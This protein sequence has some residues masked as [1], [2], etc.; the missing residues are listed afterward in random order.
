M[1][2]ISNL[3]SMD[4]S[5]V[6]YI[7]SAQDV[8]GEAIQKATT[9]IK[10]FEA[11][12]KTHTDRMKEHWNVFHSNWL[13][14]TAGIAAAT[15][16]MMKAW[17]LAEKAAQFEEQQ[18]GL[19]ALASQYGTT[20][21]AVTRM[22]KEAVQGQLSL[23]ESSKLAARALT[24]G[25][26]PQQM[27]A[28][29]EVSER[30]TDVV[31]GDIPAAFEAME[32][33]AATG[34]ARG[35]VQ[36]GIVVDLN[37]VLKKYADAHGIAKESISAHTAMQI[38]ANAIMEEAKRVTDRFGEG[39][40]TTADKMNRMRATVED[41]QL[42]LGQ[43]L[44]RA[45]LAAVGV[46]DWLKAGV[47][48][49][50]SSVPKVLEWMNRLSAWIYEKTGQE[51]RAAGA[52]REANRL[53]A[54]Y[55]AMQISAENAAGAAGEA[56]SAAFAST[57][58]LAKAMAK[59]SIIPDTTEA[60]DK[61]KALNDRI[62]EQTAKAELDERRHAEWQ[63]AEW[64]KQGAD[65]ILV[66]NWL[67]AEI[68]KIEAK[69]ADES[70]KQAVEAV[71]KEMEART[72]A[73]VFA[74][75]MREEEI[76]RIGKEDK[77]REKAVNSWRQK[78]YEIYEE[79]N[80]K[81]LVQEKKAILA[82]EKYR[83]E[84]TKS[85]YEDAYAQMMTM[86]NQVGGETGKGLGMMGAGLKGMTDIEMRQDKYSQEI[87]AA[88]EHY[89]EMEE[90]YADHEN[91]MNIM[92]QERAQRDAAIERASAMQRVN[93]MSSMAGMMA[94]TMYALYQATGQQNQ[95][96]L[97]AYKVF[98]TAQAVMDTYRAANS[99]LA[100][101]PYPY[102]FIVAAAVVAAGLANVAQIMS[103]GGGGGTAATGATPAGGGGYAYT[104]PTEPS[105]QKAEPTKA[106]PIINITILGNVV[107]QG[108]FVRSII[109]DIQRAYQDGV[110]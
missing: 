23:V 6:N 76:K 11:D 63:A 44:V 91:F 4:I 84:Y 34:R 56:F 49:V 7:I 50:A 10:K 102:N 12:T 88:I 38:R 64:R 15:V 21:D 58:E 54:A 36:Y 67:A 79:W 61:I 40:D 89:Y 81:M 72:E 85:Q 70:I 19:Q 39:T 100:T 5:A 13:K 80:A 46:F 17:D 108:Q 92:T 98:A 69:A 51:D 3:A 53:K 66:A 68:K 71:E 109:P 55:D 59:T 37:Q 20:A 101:V 26:N 62:R 28:F 31:G 94:G 95:V 97:T 22:A 105:W 65:K 104:Q 24:I 57:S 29:L 16:T 78:E 1:A 25:L 77:D 73:I 27:A 18:R 75:K 42:M 43:G 32:R 30:L 47:L 14:V 82:K 83:Q 2:N 8:S 107:D 33:A 52:I 9:G 93:M 99:A 35:L 96:F 110:H 103:A 41:L 48:S 45:G 90:L 60:S 87:D 74:D 106:A 86:A